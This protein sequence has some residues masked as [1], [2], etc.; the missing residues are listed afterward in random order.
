MGGVKYRYNPKTCKYEPWYLRGRALQDQVAGFIGLSLL[1]A[2]GFFYAF[3]S[4]FDSLNEQLLE[5]E[6]LT[7]KTKWQIL[8]DRIH[9]S[10]SELNALVEKDDKTYRA[11]LDSE[12]LSPEVREG[13][14]GGSEKFA[15]SEIKNFP[16]IL[17]DYT[18]LKKL[19]SK[20][21]VE[22]QSF[23]ELDEILNARVHMWASR[24]A[25]QPISNK[26][27]DQLHMSYGARLHPIHKSVRDHNGL[28][29]TASKGTPVYATGDG[30]VVKA[31]YSETYGKV[32]F[33]EHGHGYETR[34]AHL[35]KFVVEP[36][37]R[38]KRGNI[39]GY[40]G[41][42]GTSVSAHLHY[43]VLFRDQHVN[44]I[45]FFQRDLSNKEYER[46]IEIG[47]SQSKALD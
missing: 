43:E 15:A 16:T 41:S 33:I 24:P 36:G 23:E 31:Y 19:K 14:A 9:H 47:N 7:L 40:V 38:V 8:E 44:P 3:V 27:L 46:L 42:T 37:D 10:F 35:S 12:P 1:L 18:I 6:N 17:Y 13:G 45:N 2:G 34:Y 39:I 26:Q 20:L 30:K 5:R 29:F 11:I 25:I 32:V 28:D 4:N 22:V 21:E